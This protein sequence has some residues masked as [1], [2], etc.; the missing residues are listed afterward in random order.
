MFERK[1]SGAAGTG[2]LYIAR[3]DGTAVTMITA[4]SAP[5][6]RLRLLT[7]RE[8]VLLEANAGGTHTSALRTLTAAAYGPS[9]SDLSATYAS[10][11]PPDGRQILFTG[12]DQ[13]DSNGRAGLYTVDVDDGEVRTIVAPSTLQDLDFPEWSPTGTQ[14]GYTAWDSTVDIYTAAQHVIDADT[15]D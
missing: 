10:F 14:I 7:R 6:T 15:L 13:D 11:R 3:A 1:V 8:Q 5:R 9:R 12:R 2:Q 4:G